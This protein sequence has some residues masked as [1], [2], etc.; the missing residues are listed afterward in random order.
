MSQDQADY[1]DA[2]RSVNKLAKCGMTT[3]LNHNALLLAKADN[4][5]IDLGKYKKRASAEMNLKEED[6][7]TVD[8]DQPWG[9]GPK[10]KISQE[11]Q[12][13]L[14]I[15]IAIMINISQLFVPNILGY[16]LY[17]CAK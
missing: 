5:K 3:M 15:G 14:M 1:Q 11:E 13:R 7:Q 9:A 4:A 16:H 10:P 17:R 6:W 8:L 12:E 2:L